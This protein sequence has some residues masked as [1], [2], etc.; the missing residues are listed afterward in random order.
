MRT[1]AGSWRKARKSHRPAI[2]RST[3]ALGHVTSSYASATLGRPIALGLV[4]N[5]RRRLD[6]IPLCSHA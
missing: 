3:P 6:Q 4:R 5:G 2:L 1:A